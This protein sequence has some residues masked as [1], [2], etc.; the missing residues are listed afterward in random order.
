M[1]GLHVYWSTNGSTEYKDMP[2][3]AD[4]PK[5]LTASTAENKIVYMT[6]SIEYPG[7]VKVI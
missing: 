2:I 4:S 3:I 6:P 5:S 7:L 1:P